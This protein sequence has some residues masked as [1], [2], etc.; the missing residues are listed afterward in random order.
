MT[1]DTWISIAQ[2]AA[3][4]AIALYAHLA[5]RDA[6]NLAEVN[7]IGKRVTTLEEQMR[8]LPDQSLV[9]ELAGDMK[10]V[11]AELKGVRDLISPLVRNVERLNDYLLTHK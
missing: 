1:V 8:H 6:A 4:G 10:E 9:N 7:A 11:R 2:W 3:T 5:K